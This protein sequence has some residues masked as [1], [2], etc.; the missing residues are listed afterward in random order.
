[1][2]N[3]IKYTTKIPDNIKYLA[4]NEDGRLWGHKSKCRKIEQGIWYTR[5]DKVLLRPDDPR[6]TFIKWED[7]EPFEV[8]RR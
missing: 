1:M 2:R 6:Y 8:K 5:E 4:R 7:E 3:K